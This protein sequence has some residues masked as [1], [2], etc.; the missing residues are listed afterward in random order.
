MHPS[1]NPFH[2]LPF[3]PVGASSVFWRVASLLFIQGC[4][5]LPLQPWHTEALTAEFTA[6]KA[7]EVRT[8]E[9]YRRLEDRLFAQLDEKVFAAHRNRPGARARALQQGQRRRPAKP[10]CPTGTA[11]SSCRRTLLSAGCCSCTGCRI[12][13]TA[14]GPWANP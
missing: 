2:R 1:P 8:F 13:L 4:S 12:R 11:A 5:D 3:F 9:D 14:C 10:P 7:D 6:D